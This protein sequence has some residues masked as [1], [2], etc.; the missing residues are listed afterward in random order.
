MGFLFPVLNKTKQ[1]QIQNS[2]T[3]CICKNER[4]L[5]LHDIMSSGMC[6][7]LFDKYSGP[8][9]FIPYSRV[10]KKI[11]M[12]LGHSLM[13]NF[14]ISICT[15]RNWLIV[16]FEKKKSYACIVKF[17]QIITIFT[18]QIFTYGNYHIGKQPSLY[19]SQT[20]CFLIEVLNQR[21]ESQLK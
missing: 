8:T 13:N 1:K 21:Q 4:M 10:N 18:A 20:I 11:L 7:A 9:V 14:Y 19:F 12:L 2:I 6:F 16:Q 3:H 15:L 17:Y 5:A